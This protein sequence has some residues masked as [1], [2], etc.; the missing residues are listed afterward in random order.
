MLKLTKLFGIHQ[1]IFEKIPPEKWKHEE[2]ENQIKNG[3]IPLYLVG[4]E[5][6]DLLVAADQFEVKII[7]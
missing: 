4:K 2:L 5:G 1:E 7:K 3:N 6:I